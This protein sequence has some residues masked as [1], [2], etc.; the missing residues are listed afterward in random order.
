LD[1]AKAPDRLQAVVEPA[2]TALGY[3][4]VGI[5]YVS[6]GRHSLLRIYIDN[7]AGITVDDCERVSRQVSAVLDVEDPIQ[8]QYTLEVSSPGLERPLF[9]PEHYERFAGNEVQVRLKVP[10][11]GRRKFK[12]LLRGVQEGAA[13][14]DSDELGELRFP[15]VDIERA[16]LVPD[17]DSIKG[18]S[19]HE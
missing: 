12:G 17:W 2:V 14:I 6:Q 3:E 16:Q 18:K 11:D 9:K 8:G 5:E 15:L 10:V 13:V 7:A 1:L 4:L 19:T